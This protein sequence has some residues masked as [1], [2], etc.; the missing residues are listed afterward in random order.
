MFSCS[1][2][3]SLTDCPPLPSHSKMFLNQTQLSLSALQ[4]ALM[5]YCLPWRQSSKERNQKDV[6]FV[7]Y[8]CVNPDLLFPFLWSQV[9]KQQ[10]N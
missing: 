8:P 3:D 1:V 6:V 2:T 10:N 4:D 7:K 9:A 5:D